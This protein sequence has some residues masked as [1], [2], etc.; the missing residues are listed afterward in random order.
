MNKTYTLKWTCPKCGVDCQN[1]YDVIQEG[2]S[3][4][5]CVCGESSTMNVK[6][7]DSEIFIGEHMSITVTQILEMLSKATDLDINYSVTYSALLDSHLIKFETKWFE[8]SSGKKHTTYENVVITK[9]NE[10]NYNLGG[11]DFYDLMS[12]LDKKLEEKNQ[13]KIKEQQRQQVLAKLTP[14]ERNLLGV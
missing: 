1:N 9:K 12:V 4:M 10:S 3:L 14:E 13:A 7:I 6:R 2:R 8:D 5:I 11:W